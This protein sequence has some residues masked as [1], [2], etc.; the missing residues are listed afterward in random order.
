MVIVMMKKELSGILDQI[1]N[2]Y[3]GDDCEEKAKKLISLWT[4]YY[5]LSHSYGIYMRRAYDLY[6]LGES[7]SYIMDCTLNYD[8]NLAVPYD[9]IKKLCGAIE[10]NKTQLQEGIT[11][12]QANVFIKWIVN[13]TWKNLSF[14]SL[15]IRS[16][17]LNGFCELAQFISLYPLEELG[18]SVT[19]NKAISCFDYPFRHSFG[20][21]DI[22]IDIDGNITNYTFLI[23]P[24]YKQFFTA[25]RCNHG[26]YYAKDENTGLMVAPDPGYFMKTQKEKDVCKQIVK[27]G[28]ILLTEEAAKIYGE[29][30]RKASI[31]LDEFESNKETSY[32]GKYY[33][34][35]IKNV[36]GDYSIDSSEVDM[37][38]FDLEIPKIKIM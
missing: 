1:E 36:S 20:T 12:E 17:S 25:I 27:N 13:K 28:Y 5:Q 30:F 32:D 31:L 35:R 18:L 14:L 23:D 24:T 6:L 21:V 33:I 11:L 4:K 3:Y 19:K 7:E 26:R 22:P 34:D 9:V 10:S 15:D 16:N 8:K 38:S 37:Y 29:G 2:V